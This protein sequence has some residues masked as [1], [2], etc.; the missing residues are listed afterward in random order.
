M[1]MMS[2]T[3]LVAV[4]GA[5]LP[6]AGCNGGAHLAARGG[7]CFERGGCASAAPGP[8]R[9]L[10]SSTGSSGGS[11]LTSS[12]PTGGA[13]RGNSA[14]AGGLRHGAQGAL[15]HASAALNQLTGASTAGPRA[16]RHPGG[17]VLCNRHCHG[18]VA[19][20]PPLLS[21]PKLQHPC[22]CP[23]RGV[24]ARQHTPAAPRRPRPSP[25]PW[26]HRR[27]RRRGGP[28]AGRQQL[29]RAPYRPP[30]RAGGGQAG[31]AAA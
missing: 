2:G 26:E 16:G 18:A 9:H 22:G 4:L 1:L 23:P 27:L 12:K 20:T 6:A 15:A 7:V 28:E 17:L 31:A 25:W 13:L 11:P 5:R 19:V 10:S 8:T 24:V 3:R 30:A 29:G 21:A 14:P